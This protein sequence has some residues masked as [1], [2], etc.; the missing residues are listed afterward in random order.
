VRRISA[1]LG[2]LLICAAFLWFG[3]LVL[4]QHNPG[5]ATIRFPFP[6]LQAQPTSQAT[7]DPLAAAG[8]T[9][10][11]PAQGQ[12]SLLNEQ[13]ALLLAGQMEPQAAA[14]AGNVSAKYVL[15]S[16][17]GSSSSTP[18][19]NNVFAWLVEYNNVAEAA[20]DKASDPHASSITH[21]CYLF[22]DANSGQELLALWT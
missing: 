5:L 9:L 17:K 18:R 20:P 6:G 21:D 11:T 13:Q 16:Y 15:F 2:G 14:Q 10:S 4:R 3:W 7:V 12:A 19:M 1:L 8:V 22:L